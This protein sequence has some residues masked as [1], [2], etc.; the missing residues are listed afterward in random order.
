MLCIVVLLLKAYRI[1]TKLADVV[2]NLFCSDLT[3]FLNIVC[4]FRFLALYSLTYSTEQS[5]A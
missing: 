4:R 1:V 5:P 3:V 2:C